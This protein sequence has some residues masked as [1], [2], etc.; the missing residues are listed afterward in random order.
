MQC[1]SKKSSMP[2]EARAHVPRRCTQ[3]NHC[4]QFEC[5]TYLAEVDEVAHGEVE[6]HWLVEVHNGLLVLLQTHTAYKH[7]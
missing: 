1:G 3:V 5:L 7:H 6:H 2:V 4:M